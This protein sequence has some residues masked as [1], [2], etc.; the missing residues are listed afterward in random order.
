MYKAATIKHTASSTQGYSTALNF[1]RVPP[2]DDISVDELENLAI[3]RRK[4]KF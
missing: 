3:E 2:V 1:Y 4:R